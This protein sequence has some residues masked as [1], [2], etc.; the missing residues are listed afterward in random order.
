MIKN[1]IKFSLHRDGYPTLVSGEASSAIRNRERGRMEA[2]DYKAVLDHEW[3]N[4]GRGGG[5]SSGFKFEA[6]DKSPNRPALRLEEVFSQ[7]LGAWVLYTEAEAERLFGGA[8]TN[9]RRPP[10]RWMEHCMAGVSKG[11]DPGAVCG[12]LWYHKMSPAQRREA[13]RRHERRNPFTLKG[14]FVLVRDQQQLAG[15]YDSYQEALREAHRMLPDASSYVS[16]HDEGCAHPAAVKTLWK[17][18]SRE[19]S[20]RNPSRAWHEER[21]REY[22]RERLRAQRDVPTPENLGRQEV[23]IGKVEA[24]RDALRTYKHHRNPAVEVSASDRAKA[25][26]IKGVRPEMLDDPD[27]WKTLSKYIEFHGCWPTTLEPRDIPQEKYLVNMGKALDVSY[28]PTESQKKSNKYGSSWL[29]EFNEGG[30]PKDKRAL[31]DRL[32]TGDGKSIITHGGKF[33]VKDWVRG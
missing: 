24:E 4:L 8:K 21:W 17:R 30:N 20:R 26:K 14:P 11:Y 32:C 33:G 22:N 13:M 27:F 23:L 12:S 7:R 5:Y 15:T 9:P 3:I 6:K 18:D 31:P 29:H 2:R 28:E 16:I 25:A 1:L 10:Q 19:A